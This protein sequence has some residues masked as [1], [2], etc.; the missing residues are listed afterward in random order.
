MPNGSSRRRPTG[1]RARSVE[2]RHCTSLAVDHMIKV[3]KRSKAEST[4]EA[5]RDS[6]DEKKTAPIFAARS[7]IF[8]RTFICRTSI[9][10]DLLKGN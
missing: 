7:S 8:A 10:D 6:E 5:T 3:H 1:N 4:S 9:T 2:R